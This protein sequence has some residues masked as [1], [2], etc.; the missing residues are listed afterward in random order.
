MSAIS[1]ETG[2]Q[3]KEAYA[4]RSTVLVGLEQEVA[5]GGNSDIFTPYESRI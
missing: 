1:A 4:E 2:W 3:V 5:P